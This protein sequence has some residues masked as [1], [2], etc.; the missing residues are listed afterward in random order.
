[1]YLARMTH[2]NSPDVTRKRILETC[3]REKVRFLRLQF[4]DILGTNKNVEIPRSQ[5]EKGLD[6]GARS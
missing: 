6:G 2:N 3:D 5:F 4:T 1:M